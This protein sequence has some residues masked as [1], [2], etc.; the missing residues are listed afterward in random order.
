MIVIMI[1]AMGFTI[2]LRS[3]SR[4]L[5][6]GWAFLLGAGPQLHFRAL[7]VLGARRRSARKATRT[8]RPA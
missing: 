3:L 7:A 5:K 6:D 2:R 4:A 1:G 8:W